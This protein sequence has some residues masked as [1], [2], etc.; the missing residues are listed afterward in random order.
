MSKRAELL[1]DLMKICRDAY[2]QESGYDYLDT[3]C[4]DAL[5]NYVSLNKLKLI[6]KKVKLEI[7]R[8]KKLNE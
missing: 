1:K 4:S 3:C 8:D 6:T 5:F 2:D 7:E